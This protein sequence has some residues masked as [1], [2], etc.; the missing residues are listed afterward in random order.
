MSSNHDYDN[1]WKT[2]LERYLYDFMWFCFPD[3]A[4]VIDWTRKPQFLDKE[5]QKLAKEAATG[6]RAV[7]KLVKVRLKT[8]EV[9]AFLIHVEVQ[10]WPDQTFAERMFVY[11]YR[12]RDRFNMP[13]V[14]LAVLIDDHPQW[15]PNTFQEDLWGCRLFFRFRVFKIL[16]YQH[17]KVE[18][19]QSQNPFAEVLL[20]QLEAIETKQT[21]QDTKLTSAIN[22]ARRWYTKGL[23]KHQILDLLQFI[24]FVIHLEAPY[25]L[26]FEERLKQFEE[27]HQMAYVSTLERIFQERG[28][29]EGREAGRKEGTL[30]GQALVI[31]RLYEKLG[32]IEQVAQ[33]TDYSPESVRAILSDQSENQIVFE[34]SSEE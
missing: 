2:M 20:A 16:A 30:K 1:P 14:N 29:K 18:L 12:I 25:V 10:G 26:K 6:Q 32:S 7:D 31:R 5:F 3:I 15:Q 21:D 27:A 19:Q 13:M 4:A 17:R 8:R 9:L 33:L 23:T 24:D 22:L 34:S 11:H 28:M